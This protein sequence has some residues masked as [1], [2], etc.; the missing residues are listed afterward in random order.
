MRQV[1]EL[2]RI[3]EDRRGVTTGSRVRG[4]EKRRADR[5]FLSHLVCDSSTA[6]S[7]RLRRD[8]QRCGPAFHRALVA[9][10]ECRDRV[11]AYFAESAARGAEAMAAAAAGRGVPKRE[12]RQQ[13]REALDARGGAGGEA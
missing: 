12:R 7:R 6:T 13:M 5:R 11:Q 9:R 8:L 4:S 2:L 3:T 1:V 10:L